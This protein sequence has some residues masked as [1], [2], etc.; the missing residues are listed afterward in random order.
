MSPRREGREAAIQFLYSLDQNPEPNASDL[1][2]F[3]SIHQASPKARAFAKT[4]VTG[5]LPHLP[6]ID[7]KIR[8]ALQNWDFGRLEVVDRNVLRVAIYEM[9]HC[10][11]TPPIVAIN[12]AIELAKR[13]GTPDSARFVNGVLDQ[14]KTALT[15]PLRTA[16]ERP[17]SPTKSQS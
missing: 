5:L 15:R 10:P 6:Q 16:A 13:L 7:G 4:M 11:E 3:W 17:G 12:E 1:E 2:L 14:L 9:F 8:G